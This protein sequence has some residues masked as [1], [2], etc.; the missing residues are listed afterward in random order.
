MITATDIS[1]TTDRGRCSGK[2]ALLQ[3]EHQRTAI[4]AD[5][6]NTF[7]GD[8]GNPVTALDAIALPHELQ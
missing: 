2:P 3:P 5:Q 6:L 4:V 7:G 1:G 8:V